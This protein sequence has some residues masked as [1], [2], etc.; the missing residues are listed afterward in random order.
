MR[1]SIDAKKLK[2]LSLTIDFG[3][4]FE[5]RSTSP[6]LLCT[7]RLTT[8]KKSMSVSNKKR[9]PKTSRSTFHKSMFI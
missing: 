4:D 7:T 3:K 1:K 5:G 2:D 9:P 8:Q 6:K